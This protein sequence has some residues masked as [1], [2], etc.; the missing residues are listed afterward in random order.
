MDAEKKKLAEA[1]ERIKRD[2]LT[3]GI[4]FADPANAFTVWN[5]FSDLMQYMKWCGS[6]K[7]RDEAWM[8][9]RE[10]TSPKKL[11]IARPRGPLDP[12]DVE[13]FVER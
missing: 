10:H 2:A 5:Q 12:L 11:Y 4:D 9:A 8:L 3:Q 1:A 6:C 13:P 7:T